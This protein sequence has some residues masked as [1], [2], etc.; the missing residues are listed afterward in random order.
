MSEYLTMRWSEELRTG[1][2]AWSV[3]ASKLLHDHARHPMHC[4]CVEVGSYLG[5]GTVILMKTFGRVV[6]V[7]P[8]EDGYDLN[9]AAAMAGNLE[10][11]YIQMRK[12]FAMAIDH[13]LYRCDLR[14]F[15]DMH[16]HRYEHK[17]GAIYIDGDHRYEAVKADIITAMGLN[18]IAI[19]GHD[20]SMDGVKRAVQEMAGKKQIQTFADDSWIY[21]PQ[22]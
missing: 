13:D 17:I 22:P 10:Q 9:D 15:A 11:V 21:I 7:D 16:A 18:I 12:R 19:G 20:Y 14:T 2:K 4:A 3:A 1:L 8:Y 6:S 5:D